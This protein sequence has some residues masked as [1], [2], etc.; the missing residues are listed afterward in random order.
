M[1]QTMKKWTAGVAMATMLGLSAVPASAAVDVASTDLTLVINDKTVTTNEDI[2][3]PFIT[4]DGRTMIP[5][6]LVSEELGYQTDWQEDGT[7]HITSDD[8]TVDVTLMV[9]ADNY[10]ANGK[11]GVF[12]TQ[13]TL[14]NDR[15]YLPARDFMELYG[16]VNWDNDTRT[17]TVKTGEPSV[18]ET[19]DWTFKLSFGGDI[20]TVGN[21]Y[22]SATNE[23]TGKVVYLT[24]IEDVLGDWAGD[25]GHYL[26]YYFNGSKVINGQHYVAI[27]RQGLV[28]NGQVALFLVPDLDTVGTT[29]ALTYVRSFNYTTDYTMA[30]GYLYY[31]QGTKGPFIYDPNVLYFAQIDDDALTYVTFE[32]D[33]PVNA[34]TLRVEDGVLIATEKDGTRHEVLKVPAENSVDVA[35]MQ[36]VLE[37]AEGSEDTLTVEEI[38]CMPGAS[39]SEE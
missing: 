19:S 18:E 16:T 10:M 7:I 14:W 5:L 21:M 30:N 38:A 17:V 37:Q 27:G 22:V 13:P 4:S 9:G 28:G 25:T 34:C 32:L 1:K 23:K 26:D 24:G 29:A 6:R 39:V 11:P 35:H 20:Q 8:G 36:Q 31:T 15:T 3:Q 33:F 2:G 12:G